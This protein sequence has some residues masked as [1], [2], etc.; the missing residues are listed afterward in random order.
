M[1]RFRAA[2]GHLLGLALVVGALLA[3]PS[4]VGIS[5]ARADRVGVAQ[6]H[7][8]HAREGEQ[9]RSLRGVWSTR[10]LANPE[11]VE[12]YDS[13]RL[14]ATFTV[15]ARTVTLQGPRRVF[16]EPSTTS[17][18]VTHNRWVRLLDQPFAGRVDMQW[19]RD[20]LADTS[21]DV[22]AIGMQY[23][24]GAPA[25]LDARGEVVAAD[26]HFGPLQQDGSRAEGADFNDFY[27]RVATYG[28][29]VDRPEPE[30][31][32]SVD[33]SGF[34]RLV[35]G[36]RSGYPL[37]LTPD[38]QALPRRAVQMAAEAPG[39]MV[40][41]N[42]GGVPDDFSRLLP[43]DLVF[44]DGSVDDGSAIDHVG[45]YLG[46]DSQGHERFV[47]SRKTVDGPTMGDVGGRSVLDGTGYY[48]VAWRAARRL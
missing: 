32:G 6:Q 41:P 46:R 23:V 4:A 43:G 9:R 48:A 5:T 19:L 24:T 44:F 8:P 47:S 16:A 14:I 45:L 22:L 38:L 17:A 21:P 10:R 15:G 12:V 26:A 39:V 13:R 31:A 25:V 1:L 36:Y 29:V 28:S 33:C 3:P 2:A 35:F 40:V 18:T 20:K 27:Q 34:M 7:P 11:R 42:V 37:V 30:E